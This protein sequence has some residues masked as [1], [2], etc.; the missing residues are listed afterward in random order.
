MAEGE[1]KTHEG[2]FDGLRR[3][4]QAAAERQHAL[5][6]LGRQWDHTV[7]AELR[8]L[9]DAL[10]PNGHVLGA[11]PV[12]AYRLRHHFAA[13]EWVWWIEHDIPPYDRYHCA[14]YRVTLSLG[15]ANEPVLSVEG[16]DG[17]E[18]VAPLT[19][20]ALEAALERAGQGAPLVIPRAFGEAIE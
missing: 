8:D 3:K 10:W 5:V 12:H 6:T 1:K 15:E 19:R 16:G 20:D 7:R 13:Q 14:A 18:R 17:A 11:V 4:Q 9:A 2:S